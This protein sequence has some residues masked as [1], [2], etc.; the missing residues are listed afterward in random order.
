MLSGSVEWMCGAAALVQEV[1]L[2]LWSTFEQCYSHKLRQ[3]RS[4]L[5]NLFRMAEVL[6]P[7]KVLVVA[8]L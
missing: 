7:M 8:H 5:D 2:V 3:M 4:L 1:N 6:H